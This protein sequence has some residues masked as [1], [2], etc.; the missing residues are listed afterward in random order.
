MTSRLRQIVLDFDGVI[1][2]GTNR[3]YIA[4]Y[5]DAILS[6]GIDLPEREIE[7]GIVRHWGESPR[8]E[9]AGVLGPSHV[10][11]DEA[12]DHYQRH[13]DERLL[14]N[15]RPLP[16]AVDAV[17]RLAAEYR[18]YLVSGM[19]AAPLRRIVERFGV[20][21]CFKAVISTS[22]TDLP[23]RQ[24]ATGYHLSELCRRQGLLAGETLCVGDAPSDIAMA[25]SCGVAVAVVLTGSL[26]RA[27]ALDLE[28]DWVVSSLA[29]L[30][31]Y[32]VKN[33]NRKCTPITAKHRG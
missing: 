19:G 15:A 6:L 25:R 2:G 18:L 28:A 7:A 32:L 9:L 33:S 5:I 22:D 1:A 26:D 4:T 27:A 17:K 23:E 14:R 11:L 13:I 3:A 29:R 20:A 21:G 12:L 30:S 8:R 31:H 24:K 16:G 10:R